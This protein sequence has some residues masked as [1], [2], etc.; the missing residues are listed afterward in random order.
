MH[1]SYAAGGL[2]RKSCGTESGH[3]RMPREDAGPEVWLCP[4]TKRCAARARTARHPA[5]VCRV[6][7]GL[8]PSQA[9]SEDLQS[10]RVA[11][12][13]MAAV[14]QVAERIRAPPGPITGGNV[15]AAVVG[16]VER[17][18]RDHD[19]RVPGVA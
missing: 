18:P 7:R 3:W 16:G 10:R 5:T 12:H 14:G 6:P 15:R 17:D 2:A 13:V 9:G 4:R 11:D 8:S 1:P 19:E